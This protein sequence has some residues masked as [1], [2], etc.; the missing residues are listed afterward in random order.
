MNEYSDN[1]L[2]VLNY[3]TYYIT[4]KIRGDVEYKTITNEN[5]KNYE[6]FDA[7]INEHIKQGWKIHGNSL[8]TVNGIIVQ[9]LLKTPP[10][11]SFNTNKQI[12]KSDD[13]IIRS[14]Y[15][16]AK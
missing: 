1:K 8:S 10:L 12:V 6:E 15:L 4:M 14:D 2:N 13:Q 3:N 9:P 7:I 11:F 16:I 5:C